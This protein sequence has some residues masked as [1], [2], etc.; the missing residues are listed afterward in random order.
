MSTNRTPGVFFSM[1]FKTPEPWPQRRNSFFLGPRARAPFAALY[2]KTLR[3]PRRNNGNT[4]PSTKTK[5]SQVNQPTMY[6]KFPSKVDMESCEAKV[7][8]RRFVWKDSSIGF[9]HGK[10]QERVAKCKAPTCQEESLKWIS[11][12]PVMKSE[13]N[14]WPVRLKS[15]PRQRTHNK[16]PFSGLKMSPPF[17]G[18][19]PGHGWKKLGVFFA[20]MLQ[21]FHASVP[22]GCFQK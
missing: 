4:R 2:P 15:W 1:S 8:V 16:W 3:I 12:I 14:E 18:I 11:R 6:R 21:M 9:L 10:F 20:L 5:N 19:N 13:S 17:G 7:M 22:N